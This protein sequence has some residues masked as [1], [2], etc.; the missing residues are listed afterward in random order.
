MM[1]VKDPPVE[2]I[3]KLWML[4]TNEYP[5]YLYQGRDQ[6]TI[7][8]GGIGPL[9]AVLRQ[10]LRDLDIA[11]D[12]IKQLVVTHAHPDHV[13]AVPMVRQMCPG[14][15]VVASEPAAKTLAAEKAVAFFCKMDDALTG[16]LIDLGLVS[17]EQRRPPL[18]ENRITVDRV[19]REGDA[20]EVD[21]GVAFRVLETPGHSDCSLS[22]HEP[23][24]NVLIISDATGYY[25]PQHDGWWPNYFTDYGAYVDSIERLA[26]I[27]AEVL[28]LS[29]N[30]VVRG[31]DDVA[32]YFRRV[33]ADT[34]A[35]H[36]RIVQQA[37]AGKSV[38][39]IAEVLGTEIHEKS[40]LMPVDFFQ[41]NCG[42]LVKQSLRHA[43]I[44]ES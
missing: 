25:M 37:N 18:T 7:F 12:R 9:G 17:D 13:M 29:H 41:K 24:R 3:D 21:E 20:V 4:G 14:I 33:L 8:E 31:S 26:G 44:G 38:R 6:A 40:P 16:S 5:C 36:E 22:F 39:E 1:L 30:G 19:V 15:Q 43:G 35:Y 28:C 2:I 27:G 10:Q 34:K 42:I 11:A 32:E 23:N